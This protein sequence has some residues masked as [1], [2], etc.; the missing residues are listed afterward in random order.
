MN[1]RLEQKDLPQGI[2]TGQVLTS[3]SINY[4]TDV[5]NKKI[6][7]ILNKNEEQSKKYKENPNAVGNYK[8]SNED[9][10]LTKELKA[11]YKDIMI[12]TTLQGN[13]RLY[14]E[15]DKRITIEGIEAIS[16]YSMRIL[17]HLF[18]FHQINLNNEIA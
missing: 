3:T 16:Q 2:N 13:A 15:E 12:L 10:Y 4:T 1:L 8:G 6:E 18:N 11:I 5:L 17:K 14:V 9:E 7:S